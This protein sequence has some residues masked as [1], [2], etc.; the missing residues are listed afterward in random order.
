VKVVDNWGER[1]NKNASIA[2]RLDSMGREA[3]AIEH[4]RRAIDALDKIVHSNPNN[5]KLNEVYMARANAYQNRI[6]VLE[7]VDP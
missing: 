6:K 2:I 7:M 5:Y 3:A 1:A 4:Y